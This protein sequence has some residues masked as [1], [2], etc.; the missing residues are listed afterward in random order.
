MAGNH[1]L[2][3]LS[4]TSICSKITKLLS[5]N[6]FFNDSAN[7]FTPRATI[8]CQSPNLLAEKTGF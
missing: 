1:H 8:I 2:H 3:A 5:R 6:P 4:L 7:G